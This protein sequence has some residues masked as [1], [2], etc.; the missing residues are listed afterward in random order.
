LTPVA[1][2]LM[3]VMKAIL[4]LH[5]IRTILATGQAI[6]PFALTTLKLEFNIV[7]GVRRAVLARALLLGYQLLTEDIVIAVGADL[8][9]DNLFLVVGDLVDDVLGTAAASLEL[10]VVEC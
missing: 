8:V 3:Y 2:W 10:E 1:S 9:N 5:Q 6:S 4:D 7:D